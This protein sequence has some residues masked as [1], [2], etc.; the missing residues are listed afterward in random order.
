MRCDSCQFYSHVFGQCRHRSPMPAG[1]PEVQPGDWCGEG[2]TNRILAEARRVAADLK[3]E[4]WLDKRWPT[5]TD[6][7][8]CEAIA[9]AQADIDLETSR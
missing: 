6:A 2:K 9:R 8:V 1:F 4:T 3:N 7:E 5:R